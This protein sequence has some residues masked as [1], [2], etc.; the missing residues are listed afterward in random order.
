M[1]AQRELVL[2]SEPLH[3]VSA[4]TPVSA[5]GA[6]GGQSQLA[7][8]SPV[9]QASAL[10]RL[11]AQDPPPV[12]TPSGNNGAAYNGLG[13][14]LCPPMADTGL[15]SAFGLPNAPPVKPVAAPTV[16]DCMLGDLLNTSIAPLLLEAT[17]K[18]EIKISFADPLSEAERMGAEG[19]IASAAAV[20]AGCAPGPAPVVRDHL[21]PKLDEDYVYSA[22][23]HLRDSS[24]K[25]RVLQRFCT[26]EGSQSIE[27]ALVEGG[28][29]APTTITI[30]DSSFMNSKLWV[31]EGSGAKRPPSPSSPLLHAAAQR[32]AHKEAEGDVS[33]MA[34]EEGGGM[35]VQDAGLLEKEKAVVGPAC[36]RLR[37]DELIKTCIR[38][39]YKLISRCVCVCVCVCV[40][41]CLL[42]CPMSLAQ[43]R[44][45]GPVLVRLVCGELCSLCACTARNIDCTGYD[46]ALG[47]CSRKFVHLL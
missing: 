40:S 13:G 22:T 26:R 37:L 42:V 23:V 33:E 20:P 21:A 32:G 16:K 27:D 35:H 30:S 44:W 8:T 31:F 6:S 47:R 14:S 9:H 17:P 36:V 12:V 3:N 28:A 11:P 15:Q 41:A 25:A 18:V 19:S 5:P 7:L 39:T 24:E 38:F 1:Q 10:S 46:A 43:V 2:V 4:P 45:C 29:P 34:T